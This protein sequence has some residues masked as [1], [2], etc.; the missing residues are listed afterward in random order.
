MSIMSLLSTQDCAD[1]RLAWRSLDFGAVRIGCCQQCLSS[2]T[3]T[4]A[5]APAAASQSRT[6]RALGDRGE[7]ETR[8]VLN[9]VTPPATGHDPSR[10]R[11]RPANSIRIW[12]ALA[13]TGRTKPATDTV[14][15]PLHA[16]RNMPQ[17]AHQLRIR[18]KFEQSGLLEWL[19]SAMM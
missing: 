10:T 1:L 2:C 12:I 15:S 7:G 13:K 18:S 4:Q 19:C 3:N 5:T 17:Q 6:P 8:R 14:R 11:L 9:S 16:S